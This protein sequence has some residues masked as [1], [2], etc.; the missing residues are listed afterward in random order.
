MFRMNSSLQERSKVALEWDALLRD[1]MLPYWHNTTVNSRGGYR[2][3]D[4]GDRSWRAQI[5]SVIK[6]ENDRTKNES[7][8][9]LVSQ[10]RLLWVFSHAHILGYSTPQHD[11]LKRAAQGYSY[12]IETMLD[13]E[14]GGFY[15]KTDVNRGVIEPHKI[16]YGQAMA[17][18]ALVEYHRASSLSDTLKH[19]CSVY[20][21]VQQRVHDNV[22]G[23]WIE[24]CE[25]DFTPLTCTGDRLPGMPDIIGFKSGDALLH[26]MEALTELYAEVKDASVRDSLV[27][28]IELL[29]KK[30]YPLSVSASCE[31]RMA[32]WTAVP[33]DELSGVSHGHMI[34]FAWL[35]L[36]AQQALGIPRD[37]D[38]FEYLLRHSLRYGFDHERGGF[39]FRGKPHEPA[40][41]T[42]KFWWVQAEGLSAL[43]DAVAHFDSDEYNETL[44]QLADWILNYQ[45]RADDG[46]WIVSTDAAGRPQNIKKAGE[47]K[48]AYHEVRA[49]T[50]FVQTFAPHSQY[51]RCQQ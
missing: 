45:I 46:V 32:D 37:W 25:R 2:V 38:H 50:K 14:Q 12:L 35:M 27:E 8:R 21:S 18:Y 3:Y 6:G 51:D 23:G 29:C 33:N 47:W 30:F 1:R 40:C 15:W 39:Y 28:A 24:H 49:I 48:A 44:T 5:K 16:L 41:D 36:H 4:P 13:R 34:E 22:H 31:Y 7:L 43:T 11:Y 20:E 9:G 17:I 26:W 19:A 42:T 10:S